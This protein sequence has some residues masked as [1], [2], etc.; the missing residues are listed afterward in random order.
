LLEHS[1][2]TSTQDVRLVN[3]SAFDQNQL[4]HFESREAM[5]IQKNH[6]LNPQDG[7]RG[8]I[9]MIVGPTDVGKSTVSRILLNYAVRY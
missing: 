2:V 4:L 8:P 9:T 1:Y 3:I 7:G 5:K 6:S